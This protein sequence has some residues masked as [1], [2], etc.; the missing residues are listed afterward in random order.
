MKE[1]K[2]SS[3]LQKDLNVVGFTLTE[4]APANDTDIEVV[5]RVREAVRLIHS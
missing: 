1:R 3:L 5:K 4:F 2:N